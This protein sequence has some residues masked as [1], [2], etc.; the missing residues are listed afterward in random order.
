MSKVLKNIEFSKSTLK[1]FN[2]KEEERVKGTCG[3]KFK[4]VC[5]LCNNAGHSLGLCDSFKDFITRG[6]S[7][8]MFEKVREMDERTSMAF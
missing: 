1:N 3:N 2:T 7:M 8:K 4:L 5:K 6:I